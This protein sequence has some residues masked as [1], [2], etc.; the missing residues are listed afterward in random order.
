MDTGLELPMRYEGL[1]DGTFA[2]GRNGL[3]M[4]EEELYRSFFEHAVEGFFQTTPDGRYLR[5]N[6][7]LARIY[8]YD[9]TEELTAALTDIKTQLYVDPERRMEFARQMQEQGSVIGFESQVYHR[10][11]RIIWISENARVVCDPGGRPVLYEGTVQDITK[12]KQAESELYASQR[13]IERVAQSSPNILYVYDLVQKRYVYANERIQKILGHTL[14]ELIAMGPLFLERFS[15]P[16]DTWLLAERVKELAD[17]EDGEVF[18]YEFRLRHRDGDWRWINA[19]ETIFT[20][21]VDG[22]PHEVI[23]TA[24]DITER[25]NTVKALLQSEDRFRK[26]VE[27]TDAVFWERDLKTGRFIYVGPQ[28]VKLLGFRVED[29]YL[30]KFWMQHVHEDDKPRVCDFWRREMAD[31]PE[32]R[33]V[34]YRMETADGRIVWIRD[35]WHVVSDDAGTPVLQGFMIDITERQRAKEEICRSQ[36]QLRALS[37]RLQSAREEERI[38]IAREIHDELGGALTAL[39]MDV[40]RIADACSCVLEKHED[41]ELTEKLMTMPGLIDRTMATVRRIAT[42]LRPPVLD[43]FGL[44]AAIEWQASEFEKR[45]GIRCELEDRW[46]TVVQDQALSTAVFRI[47]QEMLTNIA[48]HSGGSHVRVRMVQERGNLILTVFDNGRGIT[49]GESQASLG[50]LGMRERAQMFGGDVKI[51]GIAGKGTTVIMSIPMDAVS[52]RPVKKS[53]GPKKERLWV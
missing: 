6:P 27:G 13:F 18:E 15:H 26:L 28:V 22:H 21:T 1:D 42:E 37:A 31:L 7:A 12:R 34:E 20:R 41:D 53:G 5:A 10:D 29:W 40:A 2:R 17:A 35:F 19:R 45:F 14:S 8:G 43:A 33:T 52:G 51:N 50:V 38:R 32:N 30:Q 4:F 46:R 16:D 49:E 47:F 39:K 3:G 24:Q 11:G 25:N 36:Q 23:G 48:R 9:S 44:S